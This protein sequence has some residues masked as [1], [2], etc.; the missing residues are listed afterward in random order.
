[1]IELKTI[2]NLTKKLRKT[3]KKN[4]QIEI[5]IIIEKTKIINLIRM[6][7]L[8]V[9]KTLIKKIKEKH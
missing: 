3:I 4:D 9:I 6:I 2:K 7:K 8:Q 1:M 5:T